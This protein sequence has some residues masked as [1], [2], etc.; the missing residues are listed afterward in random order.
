MTVFDLTEDQLEAKFTPAPWYHHFPDDSFVECS[1]RR[2]CKRP[3]KTECADQQWARN[4]ALIAKAPELYD[5][6][7]ANVHWLPNDKHDE[8][9]TLLAQARGHRVK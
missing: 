5:F 4:A 8:A 7:L 2:V 9:L 1:G 6:L 3:P